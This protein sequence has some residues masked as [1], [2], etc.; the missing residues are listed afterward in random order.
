MKRNNLVNAQVSEWEKSGSDHEKLR[1]KHIR[2]LEV[3]QRV[4]DENEQLKAGVVLSSDGDSELLSLRDRVEQLT[5]QVQQQQSALADESA[6]A[7]KAEALAKTSLRS[8]NDRTQVAERKLASLSRE[9]RRKLEEHVAALKNERANT[10][11]ARAECAKLEEKLASFPF[12][13]QS[14]EAVAEAEPHDTVSIDAFQNLQAETAQLRSTADL[15]HKGQAKLKTELTERDKLI[16]E[17]RRHLDKQQ[18]EARE[19]ADQLAEAKA[20]S[21]NAGDSSEC[22]CLHNELERV[23]AENAAAQQQLR[24]MSAQ[25]IELKRDAARRNSQSTATA[26]VAGLKKENHL[27]KLQVREM[28]ATQRKFLNSTATRTL[29]LGQGLGRR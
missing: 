9:H 29:S 27:L 19:R 12:V 28:Q 11:V 2:T 3:L 17:L 22:A 8:A 6:R 21:S 26:S 10:A 4:V 7:A 15:L 18:R 13:S 1:A 23:K 25:L 16:T 20:R 24:T 14:A 5:K